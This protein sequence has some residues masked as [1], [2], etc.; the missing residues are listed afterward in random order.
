MPAS[1]S[2]VRT[3][4]GL[5]LFDDSPLLDISR[6]Q[7]VLSRYTEGNAR[8]ARTYLSRERLFDE[9]MPEESTIPEK[10]GDLNVEKLTFILGWILAHTS[11]D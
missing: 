4:V 6:R 11:E 8:V 5:D 10:S 2:A 9:I 1:S 3:S 7:E